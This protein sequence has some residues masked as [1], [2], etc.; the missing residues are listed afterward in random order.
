MAYKITDACTSCG[1]C[2]GVCPVGA[3]YE[4]NIFVIEKDDC[5]NCGLC[6]DACPVNAIVQE[7]S[8]IP[9]KQ[10]KAAPRSPLSTF[11]RLFRK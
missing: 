10:P 2:E 11:A 9:E 3:I 8:A 6:Q 5:L 1:E 7:E 4:D